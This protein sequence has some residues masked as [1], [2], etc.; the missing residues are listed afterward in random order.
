MMSLLFRLV[1]EKMHSGELYV[2]QLSTTGVLLQSN[3]FLPNV[4]R[5]KGY[6]IYG[7]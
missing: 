6:I 5:R 2:G 4:D 7:H 1:V 3:V